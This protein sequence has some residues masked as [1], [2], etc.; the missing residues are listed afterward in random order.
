MLL[1]V[2]TIAVMGTSGSPAAARV[3]TG[4]V[5]LVAAAVVGRTARVLPRQAR[6]VVRAAL[7]TDRPL[8][9]TYIAVTAC[10]AIF[11]AVAVTGIG[12]L[13][14][15]AWQVLVALGLLAAA[16]RVVRGRRR[17]RA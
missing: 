12:A 4:V 13:G 7:R 16:V 6:P 17:R 2:A 15:V 11:L 5:L 10:V 8:R 3:V 1:F 14:A 9:F